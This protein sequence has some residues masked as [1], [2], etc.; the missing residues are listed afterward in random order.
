MYKTILTTL[1]MGKGFCTKID[2]HVM[3]GMKIFECK[4]NSYKTKYIIYPTFLDK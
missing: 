2:E 3:K 4:K 1:P